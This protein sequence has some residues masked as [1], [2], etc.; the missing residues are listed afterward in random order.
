MTSIEIGSCRMQ[1]STSD[2]REYFQSLDELN[3]EQNTAAG[4]AAEM[5][6]TSDATKARDASTGLS[7]PKRQP[8]DTQRRSRA[9]TPKPATRS[10]ELTDEDVCGILEGSNA[11]GPGPTSAASASARINHNNDAALVPA[12]VPA[13]AA[14]QIAPSPRPLSNSRIGLQIASKISV[15]I[16]AIGLAACLGWYAISNDHGDEPQSMTGSIRFE[17][18]APPAAFIQLLRLNSPR[19]ED[20]VAEIRDGQFTFPGVPAGDYALWLA[21]ADGTP[22][23]VKPVG[24]T[25]GLLT[26]AEHHL[27]I[28][29]S[30][31]SGSF[32]FEFSAVKARK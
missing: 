11:A 26:E 21:T 5:R 2:D 29:L 4:I 9:S 22:L 7:V 15:S 10:P 30:G 28:S 13:T 23:P 18:S 27:R 19:E 3:L 8:R 14:T 12:R 31:E 1:S 24:A 20:F 25:V 6:K 16:V 17:G 32:D